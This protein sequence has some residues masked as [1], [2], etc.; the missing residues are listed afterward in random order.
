MPP[1]STQHHQDLQTQAGPPHDHLSSTATDTGQ[2]PKIPPQRRPYYPPRQEPSACQHQ[3]SSPS[4]NLPANCATTMLETNAHVTVRDAPP[5]PSY[6]RKVSRRLSATVQSLKALD[7]RITYAF[8]LPTITALLKVAFYALVIYLCK[9]ARIGP[10]APFWFPNGLAVGYLLTSWCAKEFWLIVVGMAAVH[11]PMVKMLDSWENT[12]V[13][14]GINIIE[15]LVAFLIIG[16]FANGWAWKDSW[17]YL[18]FTAKG[19]DEAES[20]KRR[21][22]TL[23]LGHP[24]TAFAIFLAVIVGALLGATLGAALIIALLGQSWD[25][26]SDHMFRLF[27]GDGLGLILLIPFFVSLGFNTSVKLPDFKRAPC[28]FAIAV[29][30]PLLIILIEVLVSATT[31][32]NTGDPLPFLSYFL[33]FPLVAWCGVLAGPI[34]FTFAT[35]CLGIAAVIAIIVLPTR[36]QDPALLGAFLN[37]AAAKIERLQWFLIIVVITSLLFIVMQEQKERAYQDLETANHQKSTFMAFLCHELRNPLH[38]IINVGSFLAEECVARQKATDGRGVT[39]EQDEVGMCNAICESSRYMADL[40]NDVLDTAK[41]EAGKVRLD[42]QLCDLPQVINSIV[43]PVKEHLRIKGVNFSMDAQL[44]LREGGHGGL[45]PLV[46]MDGTRFRQVLSNLMSNAVKFTPEGGKVEL[47]VKFEELERRS[48]QSQTA[49]QIPS[50]SRTQDHSTRQRGFFHFLRRSRTALETALPLEE[51]VVAENSEARSRQL[52]TQKRLVNLE[53]RLSDNGPGIP[54]DHLP[55]L[56]RPY[57]QAPSPYSRQLPTQHQGSFS[58]SRAGEMGGTGLGLSIVKQIVDLWGGEVSVESELGSGSTFR[59]MLPV[60]VHEGD[61]HVEHRGEVLEHSTQPEEVKEMGGLEECTDK[62]GSGVLKSAPA[63]GATESMQSNVLP[64]GEGQASSSSMSPKLSIL[65]PPASPSLLWSAPSSSTPS[66]MQPPIPPLP[67]ATLTISS[68]IQTPRTS[69]EFADVRV[70][71]VDDSSINRKI[72]S[73]ILQLLGVKI[74]QECS[75]GL[76]ALEAVSGA[77]LSLDS[78]SHTDYSAKRVT[79]NSEGEHAK[80]FDIIFMDIQM[81]VLDGMVSTRVLRSWGCKTPIVAVTGN[82]ISDKE[83]FLQHGFDALA[84]KP[85]LKVD[86]EK[87]LKG[88]L[89]ARVQE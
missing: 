42:H 71:I 39:I 45:P 7:A 73:K 22:L 9:V 16:R 79:P 56:F 15:T 46:E 36:P 66:E 1:I 53:I 61:L 69:S 38:A 24:S 31:T 14:M 75:N 29:L 43:S 78:L 27:C 10:F 86:A 11:V 76:E 49:S 30:C 81:P 18:N 54:P 47:S 48:H 19:R 58:T 83:G 40:I 70:L 55:S 32:A 50:F 33:S 87:L 4:S 17:L 67:P 80:T 74:I 44:E 35:L 65:T 60:V 2:K 28:T 6:L 68:P 5:P 82:H 62:T 3:D 77:S 72:L 41:F 34:G 20:V 8:T 85:F 84:P 12:W 23:A 59:V 26:Y 37:I 52:S 21:G 64:V 51:I 13:F 88:L 89:L 63:M 25:H 57:Y